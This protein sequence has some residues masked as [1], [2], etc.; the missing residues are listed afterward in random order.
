MARTD[1]FDRRS[2]RSLPLWLPLA[3]AALIAARIISSRFEVK[4]HED[5][6]RWVP[7]HQARVR[8]AALHKP[9]LY[10]FSA[11]W[12]GPCHALEK[13]VF[14]DAKMS[15]SINERFVPVRVVDRRREDGRN[16]REVEDLQRQFD[17]KGFPTVVIA[18]ADGREKG[19]TVGY[20]GAQNF[21]EFL[22]GAH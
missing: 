6:V 21:A 9:I 1:L 14:F 2:Q 10:E 11:D 22:A 5:L 16:S 13:A 17:V 4:S 7:I 18:E 19:K 3:V 20:H 12:C 15:A 8:S